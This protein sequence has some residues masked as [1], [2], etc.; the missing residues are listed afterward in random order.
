MALSSPLGFIAAVRRSS[1]FTVVLHEAVYPRSL[2]VNNGNYR[3][4]LFP[5]LRAK[6]RRPLE[7]ALPSSAQ[8]LQIEIAQIRDLVFHGCLGRSGRGR[9]GTMF[10]PHCLTPLASRGLS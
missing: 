6:R 1:F 7:N 2:R 9:S 8:P 3:N 10:A 5:D 4:V